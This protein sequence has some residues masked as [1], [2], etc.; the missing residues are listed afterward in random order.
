MRVRLA[1]AALSL[2]LPV[3]AAPAA[4]T[5]VY[6]PA[7]AH[8]PGRDGT[9]WV[10]EL[11][12]YNPGAADATV[13]LAFLPAGSDNRQAAEVGVTVPS[14]RGVVLPDVVSRTFGA[15]GGGSVRLRESAP[16]LVASRTFNVG[17]PSAGTFGVSVPAVPASSALEKGLI[18]PLVN[19]ASR[20]NAGFLNPSEGAAKVALRLLDAE[21]GAL[22]AS[23]EVSVPPLG[24][25]QVDDVFASLG[26]GKVLV[27]HAV[28]SFAA[29][30][31]VIGWA[32]VI[33][34]ASGDAS[35]FAAEPE[36]AAPASSEPW[37]AAFTLEPTEGWS[38]QV[39]SGF[40]FARP[41]ASGVPRV[42]A[43]P[44]GRLRLYTP[45]QA[46][47]LS[48]TSADGFTF[49]EDPG[50]RGAISDAAVVYLA[51][52]GYRF[53]WPDGPNGSQRLVSAISADGLAMTPEPGE[54][55]RPAP[56]D[57]GL[58]QVPHAARL[59]DGRWRLYYVADWFGSGGS[60]QR[61][62]TRTAV[63]TDEGLT[64]AAE[65]NA[66]TGRDSVDPDVVHLAGGGYRLYFKNYESFRAADS[67]DGASFPASGAA[68]RTVLDARER[69]DPTVVKLPDGT[70]RMFFGTPGGVG[71]AVATD[72]R[73]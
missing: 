12:L 72:T 40:R 57:A 47:L 20:S 70:V 25:L 37:R 39:E 58:V 23:G 42:V 30:R 29:D 66:G 4:E 10:T 64:W 35:Y 51:A 38:W 46:G 54:R 22:L 65:S 44:D 9:F 5:V 41:G 8:S 61:N 19:A 2:L 3:V 62:N 63:S 60:P 27:P 14:R 36:P 16:V 1:F 49:V 28:L 43:L 24:F 69:F 21:D 48:A 17:H 13:T 32:T 71:S 73:R 68:G 50:T 45:S 31:A 53:L 11:R 56:Q 55:F 59:E 52:G 33:D 6:V 15:S 26:S 7:A 34:S 67:A 18:H